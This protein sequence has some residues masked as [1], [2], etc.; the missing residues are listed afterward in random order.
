MIAII[1]VL[2]RIVG[3]ARAQSAADLFNAIIV[4]LLQLPEGDRLLATLDADLFA[5]LAKV[6]MD[7]A[8]AVQSEPPLSR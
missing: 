3:D 2:I 8:L 7:K 1:C 4:E 6:C 5:E